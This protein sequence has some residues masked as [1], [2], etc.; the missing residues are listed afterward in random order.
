MS[1][2]GSGERRT[3]IGCEKD[4]SSARME[5]EEA[6]EVVDFGV[7]NDPLRNTGEFDEDRTGVWLTRSSAVSCW[8][9]MASGG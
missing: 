2:W 5:S 3:D 9:E 4:G 1:G 6:G 7:N 8:M